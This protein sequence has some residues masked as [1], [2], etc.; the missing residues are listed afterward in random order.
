MFRVIQF[1]RPPWVLAEN[2]P[3]LLTIESGLVFKQIQLD[4]ESE[5][6]EVQPL[7]IP[8]LS[9]NAPHKRDRLWIIAYNGYRDGQRKKNEGKPEDENRQKITAKYKRPIRC[10]KLRNTPDTDKQCFKKQ[11]ITFSAKK[12]QTIRRGMGMCNENDEERSNS[13]EREWL[14]VATEL[15]GVDDGISERLD[16]NYKRVDRLKALGNAIVPQIAYELFKGILY[17]EKLIN[18]KEGTI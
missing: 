6:Y 2:V 5:G 17:Q 18:F 8:A 7:I 14:E 1:I 9:K 15:C 16:K 11:L 3:G 13:W 4:L 10:N 12:K